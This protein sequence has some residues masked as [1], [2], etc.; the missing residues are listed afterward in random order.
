M[1]KGFALSGIIYTLLLLF[2]VVLLYGVTSLQNQK[3]IL[4]QLK[5]DTIIEIEKNA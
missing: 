2:M 1:K 5:K 3:Q 4:D